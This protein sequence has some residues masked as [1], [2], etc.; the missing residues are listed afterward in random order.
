M[1]HEFDELSLYLFRDF[2]I[3]V[4]ELNSLFSALTYLVAVIAEPRSRLD[5]HA[6]FLRH[7][8]YAAVGGNALAEDDVEFRR[9]EGGSEL[10]FHDL[11]A[12]AVAHYIRAVLDRVAL[13]DLYPHA[14]IKFERS[15]ARGRFGIAEHD[16]HLFAQLIDED[17]AGLSLIDYAREL[18]QSLGHE[19][20][21]R[22][23]GGLIHLPF[24]LHAGSE[25]RHRVD[26]DYIHGVAAHEH[27]R[28]V[29]RL[30]AVV[31]LRDV[32]VAYV[33]AQILGID[34]IER[35]LGVDERR[36]T[37]AALT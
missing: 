30:F 23:H 7:I 8:D 28:D 19:A 11:G 36:R 18:S 17:Y 9:L 25:R 14:R 33:H 16:A 24:Y 22:A 32:K 26:D 35:M 20:R 15:A 37:A 4:Q 1:L 21:L 29:E 2:G 13:S 34:G 6:F 31:G 10:V 12:G 5:D 3:V 27:F